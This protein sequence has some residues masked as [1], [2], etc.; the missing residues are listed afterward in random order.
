VKDVAE[1][2][3]F[4]SKKVIQRGRKKREM[5]NLSLNTQPALA[6]NSCFL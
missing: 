1:E 4:F 2:I 6:E 5:D 3:Q